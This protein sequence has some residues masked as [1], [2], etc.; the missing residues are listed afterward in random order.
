MFN[1]IHTLTLQG[2]NF[3]DSFSLIS[4]A[5]KENNSITN[6]EISVNCSLPFSK[7]LINVNCAAVKQEVL[8][9]EA[10]QEN[11]SITQLVRKSLVGLPFIV[12]PGFANL[13]SGFQ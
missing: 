2:I 9:L 7:S 6:L 1:F 10:L 8:L 3:A 12:F 4:Q 11:Y 5:I 13:S